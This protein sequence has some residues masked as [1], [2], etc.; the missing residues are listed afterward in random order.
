ML[1]GAMRFMDMPPFERTIK[2]RDFE[3]F[4]RSRL[5]QKT[6]LWPAQACVLVGYMG[7]PNAPEARAA[8]TRTLQDWRLGLAAVPPRLRRIQIDWGRVADI[9]NLHY[10]LSAGAHQPQ[11]AGASVGKA[12]ELLARQSKTKG[13]GKANLWKAWKRYKDV[14]HLIAAATIIA[15]DA[16]E[17]AKV[18]AFGDS[19]LAFD[20]IQPALIATLMPDF[21]LSVALFLQ[22][23][24]LAYVPQARNESMLD[25]A[26]LWRISSD[27]KVSPIAP[28]KRKI[29]KKGI[30]ILNARRAG[31]R[32]MRR[33]RAKTTL[34][35][36]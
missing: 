16:R 2:I 7:W 4:V 27:M 34:V 32:G 9:V 10:D 23:Y 28:P 6:V 26:T 13:V 22:D 8:A 14:A 11:R 12:I 17:R 30:A 36:E 1:E 20:Q 15:A 18:K 31:N 33:K 21:V 3:Y 19:G 24:G 5:S 35:S 25:P 29:G